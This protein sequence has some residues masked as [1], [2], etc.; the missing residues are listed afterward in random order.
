MTKLLLPLLAVALVALVVATAPAPAK[1]LTRAVL[2]GSDG[3]SVR[4]AGS[5]REFTDLARKPASKPTRAQGGYVRL[6]FVGPGDFPANRA[7]YY[8]GKRCIALDWPTYERSCR[9][10]NPRLVQRFGQS[11][12]FARFNVQPTVLSRLRYPSS[13][14][15]SPGPGLA[16]SVELALLRKGLPKPAASGCYEFAA[17]WVGPAA[18]ER[19]RRLSLCRNGAYADGHLHSLSRVVWEW[20][21]RNFGPPAPP[22]EPPIAEQPVECGG[23]EVRLLVERFVGAFNSGDFMAL[24]GLF[25]EE[26]DF[27]WYSTGA[28]GERLLP[29]AAERASLVP[30]FQQRH[31]LGERLTMSSFRFNGNGRVPREDGS[32]VFASG[33]QYE[34]TRSADDLAPTVYGGKGASLCYQS[35]PDLL[36]VWSMGPRA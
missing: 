33:F 10:L 36:I 18:D 30:Y 15:A 24:D 17:T 1:T 4:V 8:P 27:K 11:H 34:L 6:Y 26:S 16:A 2:V 25:A 20:F 13:G 7:R 21:S 19:P 22:P 3:A 28:P 35:R 14:R 23:D 9:A 31:Q 12:R 5:A 32:F 29:L